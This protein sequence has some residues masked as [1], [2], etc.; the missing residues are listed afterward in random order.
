MSRL[1]KI[2]EVMEIAKR[3]AKRLLELSKQ[4]EDAGEYEISKIVWSGHKLAMKEYHEAS[5]F[6][7]KIAAWSGDSQTA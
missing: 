6:Y 4:Y 5:Y 2:L 1:E 7:T 3:D